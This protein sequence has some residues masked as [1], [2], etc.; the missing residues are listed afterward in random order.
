MNPVLETLSA[1]E[2]RLVEIRPA[3]PRDAQG[4][5]DLMKKVAVEG[6]LIAVEEV[7]IR[8][9]ALARYFRGGTWTARQAYL[10]AAHDKLVVGQLSLKRDLG[11]YAHLAEL[12]MSV[13]DAFRGQGI[14]RALIRAAIRWAE[15]FGVEKLTLM[16]FP[17]NERAINV[18]RSMG[19]E[20]E[21]HRKLH[22]KLSY[23]YEDLIE[24]SYFV[25]L[26]D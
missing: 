10:V 19:F 24:M 4:W 13:A 11:I 26:R 8:K 18:Y 14:G 20:E 21:G 23:G 22:A 2:G 7:Q 9:G 3:E 16:V 6:P 1:G 15:T 5:I 12:G 17:H 25:K